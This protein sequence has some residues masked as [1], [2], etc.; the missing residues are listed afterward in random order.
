MISAHSKQKDLLKTV[1]NLKSSNNLLA[2][3]NIELEQGI[4]TDQET[5]DKAIANMRIAHLT[6]DDGPS[7]NTIKLLDILDE[8]QA[9]ATFFV[10][11]KEGYDDVYR[12]IVNRGHVLANHTAS[13]NYKNIYSDA[14]SFINDIELLDKK[15]EEITG[16]VPSKILRFP[17]GSNTEHIRSDK[18][19][20]TEIIKSVTDRGY[21][22]FDWNVDSRDACKMTQDKNVIIDS[23][24][25]GSIPMNTANILM[26]DTNLKYTTIEA[27]PEILKGLK[28]QGYIFKPLNHDSADI[29]FVE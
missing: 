15:L 13:H 19:I 24:L 18:N 8:Y 14:T 22:Y 28:S 2:S 1:E 16:Q 12:E 21:T 4:K 29:R 3:K 20:M 5:Y 6:F 11:Y 7:N 26:H 10:N 9:K 27:M 25:N 23:V 17:G